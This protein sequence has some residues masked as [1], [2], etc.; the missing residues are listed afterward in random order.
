MRIY[1]AIVYGFPSLQKLDHGESFSVG[2]THLGGTPVYFINECNIAAINITENEQTNKF[3]KFAR[4]H[5]KIPALML[6][7]VVDFN[8]FE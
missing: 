8:P 7:L 3:N 2:L 5:N 4:F 1:P 6:V